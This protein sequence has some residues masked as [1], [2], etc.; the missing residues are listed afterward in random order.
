[1]KSALFT[2]RNTRRAL[3]L[4]VC[5][6]LLWL[7]WQNYVPVGKLYIHHDLSNPSSKVTDFRPG[8]LMIPWQTADGKT[9]HTL[10]N[11]PIFFHIH[12]PRPFQ[13]ATFT[14]HYRTSNEHIP[15]FG[16]QTGPELYE[17]VYTPLDIIPD[18]Q[19]HTAQVEFDLGR[20]YY[21][22]TTHRYQFSFTNVE[23]LDI[24]GFDVEFIKP[25]ITPNRLWSM[26]VK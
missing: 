3:I 24:A 5:G 20:M 11:G 12:T 15:Q 16:D 22:E 21:H 7:L 18:G 6:L 19:W 13:K 14:I 25:P 2:Q 17:F 9:F 4:A 23:N 26:M 1:M 10:K 8:E